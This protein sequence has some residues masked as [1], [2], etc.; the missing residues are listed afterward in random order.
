MYPADAV[1][2]IVMEDDDLTILTQ[3]HVKLDAVA[4][5]CS[6]PERLER[7]F[8]HAH[9]AAVQTAVR[10]VAPHERS[11]LPLCRPARCEQEQ[12][13]CRRGRSK[14]YLPHVFG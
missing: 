7:I 9:V 5:L 12:R 4:C 10:K 3:L 13:H 11:L 2:R 6:K 14:A 1:E 8:R